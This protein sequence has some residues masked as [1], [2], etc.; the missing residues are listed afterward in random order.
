MGARS[1]TNRREKESFAPRSLKQS[2]SMEPEQFLNGNTPAS[3]IPALL[4]I[5]PY[6]LFRQFVITSAINES[7]QWIMN[8]ASDSDE[9]FDP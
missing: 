7:D 6:R 8:G 4:R 9:S 1:L 3:I 5:L 2:C